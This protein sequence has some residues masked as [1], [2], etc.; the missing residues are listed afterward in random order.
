MAAVSR[1]RRS[2]YP[3]VVTGLI[4]Q[5]LGAGPIALDMWRSIHNQSLGGHITAE[6]IKFAWRSELHSRAGLTVLA[7]GAVVY[8]SGS[9]VMARP[10]ISRPATLFIAVP[11]AAVA[12]LLLLGVLVLVVAVLLLALENSDYSGDYFTVPRSMERRKRRRS[13]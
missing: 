5:I 9:V 8:A 7:A 4:I 13:F 11:I 3:W 2:P 12:G 6:M 10:D 1:A